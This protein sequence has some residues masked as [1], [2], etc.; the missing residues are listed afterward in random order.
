M[1]VSVGQS[2]DTDRMLI[3]VARG[4][5]HRTPGRPDAQHQSRLHWKYLY[6]FFSTT[7]MQQ[8]DWALQHLRASALNPRISRSLAQTIW[9]AGWQESFDDGIPTVPVTTLN[10]SPG[11]A[12]WALWTECFMWTLMSEDMGKVDLTAVSANLGPV[13]IWNSVMAF[14]E[15]LLYRPGLLFLQ[16]LRIPEHNKSKV[17]SWLSLLFPQYIDV[18]S[19]H[20]ERVSGYSR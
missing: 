15:L 10:L 4:G 2:A 5:T 18:I 17:K 12:A 16:D 11:M 20:S 1:A 9:E 13:G 3:P 6:F 14:R 7:S 19:V 8:Q